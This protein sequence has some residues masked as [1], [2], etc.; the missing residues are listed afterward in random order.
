MSLAHT[1]RSEYEQRIERGA[2]R[3]VCNGLAYSTGNPVGGR[4]AVVLKRIMGIE[5]RVEHLLHLRL[6]HASVQFLA[7][8][9]RCIR[10]TGL[11]NAR[12]RL[13][14]NL[15]V[16]IEQLYAIAIDTTDRSAENIQICILDMLFKIWRGNSERQAPVGKPD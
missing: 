2:F 7:P 13:V 14:G 11:I 16:M 10:Q 12:L 3:I 6:K 1:G 9:E 15:V 5:L 4:T 8:Q